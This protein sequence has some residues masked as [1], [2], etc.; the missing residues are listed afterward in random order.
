MAFQQ[1]AVIGAAALVA[2]LGFMALGG[3]VQDV[4]RSRVSAVPEGQP[5]SELD[6]KRTGPRVGVE[7]GS[8]THAGVGAAVAAMV[9]V[10]RAANEAPRITVV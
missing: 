7:V 6:W 3:G 2:T 8:A 4:L 9:D 10:G 5:V 1:I